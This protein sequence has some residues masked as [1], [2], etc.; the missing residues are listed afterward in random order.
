MLLLIVTI[1]KEM[2][3]RKINGQK[4]VSDSMPQYNSAQH[5]PQSGFDPSENK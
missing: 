1:V 5:V 3:I 2:F 4:S